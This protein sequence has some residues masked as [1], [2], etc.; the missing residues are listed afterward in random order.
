MF[1]KALK[2][3]RDRTYAR[4]EE[5]HRKDRPAWMDRVMEI[6]T[7]SSFLFY[8]DEYMEE[9]N[10]EYEGSWIKALSL[11]WRRIGE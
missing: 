9:E 11:K 8:F 3:F 1:L 10:L 7:A 2:A 6:H 5:E 4:Y